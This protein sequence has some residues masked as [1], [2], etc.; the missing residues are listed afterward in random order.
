MVKDPTTSPLPSEEDSSVDSTP[1][2]LDLS[3]LCAEQSD[4]DLAFLRTYGLN[5][6][7][8]NNSDDDDDDDAYCMKQGEK[9]DL[10]RCTGCRFTR[11]CSKNCQIKD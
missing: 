10:R 4:Q 2:H 6:P 1:V 3:E 11:Y 9:T 7:D 8:L 5:Q